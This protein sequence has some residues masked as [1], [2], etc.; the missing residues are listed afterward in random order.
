MEKPIL[1]NTDMVKAIL[2]GSKTQ[3]RRLPSSRIRAA[4]CDW[5]EYQCAVAPPGSRLETEE[6]FY[7]KS[8]IRKGLTSSV[9]DVV[10]TSILLWL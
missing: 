8:Q 7:K 4:W 1:F 5:D 10:S 9:P 3:T 6:G 2:D